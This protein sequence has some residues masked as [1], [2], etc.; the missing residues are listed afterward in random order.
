MTTSTQR[1]TVSRR[2]ALASLGVGGL[3]LATSSASIG[4]SGQAT[5]E[6]RAQHPLTG[7]WLAMANPPIP[8]DPQFAAPSYFGVDGSVVLM[9]PISQL[10]PRGV[11]FNSSPLGVWEPYDEHT[12]HFTAVQMLTDADGA[13]LGTVT[14]DGYPVVSDDGQSFI[15]E[16]SL[17]V[18]TIR[19]VAG[20]IIET[21]NTLAGQRPVTAIRMGVGT[22][23]FPVT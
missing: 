4:A 15:D 6:S 11:Q 18:I 19:D 5:P 12:G 3:A 7:L 16:G 21:A 14:I 17:A 13:Y 1:S 22:P 2:T 20:A 10:G 9:F 8:D 23:G